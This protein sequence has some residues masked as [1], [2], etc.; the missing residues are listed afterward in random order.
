MRILAISAVA[1]I[2]VLAQAA[3]A[4]TTQQQGAGSGKQPAVRSIVPTGET[5]PPGA[6]VAD[7]PSRIDE[8]QKKSDRIG[9]QAEQSICK[10]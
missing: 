1:A 6:P 10:C 5:K 8:L 2:I 4:Q 3:S 9:R 7:G